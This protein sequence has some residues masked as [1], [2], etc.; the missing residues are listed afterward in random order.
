MKRGDT[1]LSEVVTVL[2]SFHFSPL[3]APL[4]L[5]FSATSSLCLLHLSALLHFSYTFFFPL[6]SNPPFVS[7]PR[8]VPFLLFSSLF[9]PSLCGKWIVSHSSLFW[10]LILQL[11]RGK[12]QRTYTH[13][14]THIHSRPCVCSYRMCLFSLPPT[15]NSPPLPTPSHSRRE[16][17]NGP[18]QNN[19]RLHGV[20]ESFI[21][22]RPER[23]P[24]AF[25]LTRRPWL[26][27]QPLHVGVYITAWPLGVKHTH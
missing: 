17:S 7:H 8:L 16:K 14:H 23:V 10:R 3:S 6:S 25:R 26:M 21:C 13:I 5:S 4:F 22:L 12:L 18:E 11:V 1:D 9:F 19:G 27:V 20:V 15:A 2:L 24:L